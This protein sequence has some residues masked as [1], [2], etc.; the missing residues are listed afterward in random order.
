MCSYFINELRTLTSRTY[1]TSTTGAVVLAMFLVKRIENYVKVS[2][3]FY[4]VMRKVL[5]SN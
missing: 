4:I 5:I 1:A 3:K 2:T